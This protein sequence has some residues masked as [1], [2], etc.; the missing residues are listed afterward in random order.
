MI[1][2]L[3]D[4]FICNEKFVGSIFKK[5]DFQIFKFEMPS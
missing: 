2:D 1:R 5:F 4:I 3:Y